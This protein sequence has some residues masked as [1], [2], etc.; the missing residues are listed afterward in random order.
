MYFK[1]IIGQDNAVQMLRS[2]VAE[3][4]IPHAQLICG[5]E[6]TGKLA[7][8][9][10]YARYLCCSHRNGEDACGECPSCKKFDKLVH[11]DL[12][13]AFPIYKKDS[14]KTPRSDD[15]IDKWRQAALENPYMNLNQWMDQIGT[16]N[17]QGLIYASQSEEIIRKLTLKSS[18][19]GY[20]VMII[21]MA[22][23]MNTEC[24]NKLLKMIE[25]PP[26]QT[27]FLLVAENPDLLLPTIQSRVQRLTL[28][29]IEES[30]ISEA[31]IGRYGLTE[32]DARQIA[33][34]SAGNWLQAVETIHLGNRT[35]EYIELF[36]ALMRQ[37]YARNL[38]GMRQ[39]AETVAGMGREPQKNFLIY[40]QRMI[41]ESFICNFH[42]PEI[43]YMNT[44]EANF[45]SR[46]APF[47][48]EKN[49]FGIMEELSE[50]QRHI[51]QNVN[52]KMVFFDLALKMIMLLKQ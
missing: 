2:A 46:F 21:W 12:H 26:A 19:G 31:L 41:R 34:A 44:D 9:I 5:P 49:I 10:A 40:C 35:K 51:E 30:I 15:F 39:W 16:E 29:P 25:E 13:F 48:N 42:R 11:P 14:N 3:G 43:N 36:M 20:K 18:E 8:A 50:A 47:V 33:H 27:V 28:R 7:V 17:Q 38:K 1:D 4:R 24:S 23:K 45:T 22:E 6:G 52:A 37:A 32:A